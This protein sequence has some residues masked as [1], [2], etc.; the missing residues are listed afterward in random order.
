MQTAA[1]SLAVLFF[2]VV[3]AISC[4]KEKLPARTEIPLIKAA[5]SQ[6]ETAVR[7]RNRP[8]LDSLMSVRMLDKNLTSDSLLSFV[9]GSIPIQRF[10]RF[11]DCDI[12]FTNTSAQCN[13]QITDDAGKTNG[14]IRL[15]F[16]YEDKRWLLLEFS[17]SGANNA[18]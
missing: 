7:E 14:G 9:W 1:H 12:S 3:L 6:V 8:A 2:L 13:C 17:T 15:L 4:A 10:A 11:S 18:Q 16:S 5:I